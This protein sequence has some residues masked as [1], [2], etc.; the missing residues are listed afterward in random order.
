VPIVFA[1]VADNVVFAVD[2]KPKS[3]RRLQR[4]DNIAAEPRVTLLF[5]HYDDEW[6]QL[7]WVRM[8]GDAH[9]V[10]AAEPRDAALDALVAKYPQYVDRR[11]AGP[12]VQI[13]PTRWS[14][15][16]YT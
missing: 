7:W 6:T 10:D 1:F 4:L 3:A 12:V 9:E 13:H 8:Q 11:P 16:S 2:H 15:W 14:G 5:D